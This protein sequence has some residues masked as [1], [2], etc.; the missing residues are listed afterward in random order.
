MAKV[1]PDARL[2]RPT[3]DGASRKRNGAVSRGDSP[4]QQDPRDTRQLL[5]RILETPHLARAVP[6]LPPAILH[7]VIES[8]GLE[9][10]GE[11]VALATPEQL[12]AV[13]DLDLWRSVHPGMEEKFDATRFGVWLEVLAESGAG[14]AAQRLAGIDVA[15]VIAA[16]AR[17]VTVFDPAVFSPTAAASG[18]EVVVNT[19]SNDSLRCEVG[20]YLVG[21]KRTDSWDTVVAVLVALDAEHPDR[22]HRVMRGCRRLSNSKPE[23]DGLDDLMGDSE[24]VWF[25]LALD[26]ESR[27]DKQGFVTPAQSRAFLQASRELGLGPDG[28]PPTNPVSAAYIRALEWTTEPTESRPL[29]QSDEPAT[30][31]ESASSVA[32]VIN[33]LVEAS[34]LPDRP[35]ALLTGGQEQPRLARIQEHLRFVRDHDP[36]AYSLRSQ[37][38]AFLANVLVAGCSV[39][40]RPFTTRE[41]Y[42]AAVAICNL[43]LENWP[44]HWLVQEPQ[45][46]LSAVETAQTLPQDFLVGHDLATVF[47]VG[48]AVLHQDVCMF[49]AERLLNILDSF[50]CRDRE[51]QLGLYQ[52]RRE[53]TRH[54]RAGAPWHARDALDV[55]AILDMPAWAALLGLIAECPVMLANVGASGPS[56]PLSI[57]VSAFQFISES[58]QIT[59]VREF[60]QL[61]PE[62]LSR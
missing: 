36:A 46:R 34:V 21:A 22:F 6:R 57:S 51:I 55:I 50:R 48:W 40:A 25:D 26:R 27:R 33:V 15:L 7:R 28:G 62:T 4:A 49:A 31:D 56:R 43:G 23:V 17:H 37:E 52:L 1:D 39:Q 35:R 41:A 2:P 9:D 45:T 20:G 60:M 58:S 13:F 16:L 44:L 53:L 29:P 19:A 61:L 47:Q 59:N 24:Q 42:D 5:A 8:C 38:L 14:V 3:A 12:S 30:S 18:D 32:A 10:C 11:L 54:W